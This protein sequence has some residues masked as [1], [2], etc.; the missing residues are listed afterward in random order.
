MVHCPGEAY[1]FEADTGVLNIDA[2]LADPADC[3]AKASA[4]DGGSRF[5]VCLGTIP[6]F[7]GGRTCKRC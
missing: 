7:P 1:V 3:F 4:Q 2:D 6:Q 5:T